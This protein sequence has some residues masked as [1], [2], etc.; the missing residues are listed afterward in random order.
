MPTILPSPSPRK[1][2]FADT[3]AAKSFLAVVCLLY[4]SV[5]SNGF[6]KTVLSKSKSDGSWLSNKP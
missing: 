1:K 5:G 6:S 2:G 3:Y 4:S